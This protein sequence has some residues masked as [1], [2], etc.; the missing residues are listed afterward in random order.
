MMC[1]AS[2]QVI[3]RRRVNGGV[4]GTTRPACSS[5]VLR[6]GDCD[7]SLS[8]QA[9]WISWNCKVAH[10][11]RLCPESDDEER[12]TLVMHNICSAP[13]L[14]GDE[15]KQEHRGGCAVVGGKVVYRRLVC[16]ARDLGT[17]QPSKYSASR[18]ANGQPCCTYRDPDGSFCYTQLV[19]VPLSKNQVI[20][21]C[22][23]SSRWS[24]GMYVCMYVHTYIK[25]IHTYL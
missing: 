15:K 24:S 16:S 19:I 17:R 3:N 5:V 25:Y 1:A 22:G 21:Q 18:Y 7:D 6:A 12:G 9:N 8:N 13:S 23:T 14:R 2:R 10:S 4:A 20:I 11:M